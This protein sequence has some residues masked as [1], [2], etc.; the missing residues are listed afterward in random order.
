MRKKKA[1]W[2][3]YPRMLMRTKIGWENRLGTH[4]NKL[5]TK[6]EHE[7]EYDTAD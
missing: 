5:I 3:I 2:N 1:A 4:I 7:S 6:A